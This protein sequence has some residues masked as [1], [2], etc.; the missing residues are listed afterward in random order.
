MESS[1]KKKKMQPG[2]MN[3]KD[4]MASDVD[5][6]NKQYFVIYQA[7]FGDSDSKLFS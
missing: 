2:E 1:L 5:L 3:I 7:V 6:E 4:P